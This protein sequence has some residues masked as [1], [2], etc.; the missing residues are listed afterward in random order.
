MIPYGHQ[1]ISDEDVRAVLEVLRS[2]FL[3]Q[4]PA[5]ERFEKARRRPVTGQI[6][7]LL[8]R[9]LAALTGRPLE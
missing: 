5:V 8:V 9:D 6:S 1:S 3:T 4:G 7:D 2:D